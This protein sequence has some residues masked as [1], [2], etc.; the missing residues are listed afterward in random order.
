MEK[1]EFLKKIEVELKIS[2]NSPYTIRNYVSLN[3]EFL[4]FTKKLPEKIIEDD[5]KLF[6]SE[7]LSTR[8][9]VSVILFLAAIRYAYS[10]IF[11]MDPTSNIK[12]PRKDKKIPVVLTKEEVKKILDSCDTKKSRLMLSLIYATG[13]RVSELTNLKSK[14]FHFDENIGFVRQAKGRK[15]RIFN[16]PSFIKEDLIEQI[17]KQKEKKQEY[18]FSGPKEKLSPRN[19]QKIVQLAAIKAGINKSV[20]PHTLR[21]S[22]ATHLL[23]RGVDI[24]MIQELLGHSSISTTE[25]YTH[26]SKEEL[27]KIQSPLDSMMGVK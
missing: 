21:H 12:R 2:K 24:R 7:K 10:N 22:Y 1:E 19:I 14:D 20:H 23:E 5:I 11:K 6:M 27:K 13:M 18:I 3:K 8:S 9:P 4:E 25:I 17:G 26:V 16:I 15:D